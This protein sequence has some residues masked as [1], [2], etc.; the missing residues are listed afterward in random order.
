MSVRMRVRVEVEVD[1]GTWG[2]DCKFSDLTDRVKR[3]GV[4]EIN[5]KLKS[6]GRVIGRPSVLAI[7][8]LED[9]EKGGG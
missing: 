3:E 2:D 8:V 7:I 5:Q 1:V 6:I 4:N 9:G